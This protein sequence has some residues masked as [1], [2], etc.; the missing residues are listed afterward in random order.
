MPGEFPPAP[1][2][3]A[4]QDSRDVD[5]ARAMLAECREVLA[6]AKERGETAGGEA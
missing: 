6:A 1:P 3:S 2:V 4:R 5:Q